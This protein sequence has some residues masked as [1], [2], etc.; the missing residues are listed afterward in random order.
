M[1]IKHYSVFNDHK[2]SKIDWDFLRKS[3]KDSEYYMPQTEGEYKSIINEKN[4]ENIIEVTS[5]YVNKNKLDTIVSLGSGRA[6]LEYKLKLKTGIRTIISDITKSIFTLKKLNFFDEVLLIDITKKLD[7]NISEKSIVILPRIDTE[8]SDSQ[9][10][11]LF[12]TLN[13][14]GVKHILFIPAQLISIKSILI[15]VYVFLKALIQNKSL[16]DCGYSRSRS[17]FKKL[18]KEFYD[19]H[20]SYNFKYLFLINKSL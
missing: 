14:K 6:A 3:K 16:V 5:N 12:K 11:Q 7:I 4:Y 15:Q 2:N 9:I 10:N 20:K 8:L 13:K 18:W 1:K 17:R 19:I